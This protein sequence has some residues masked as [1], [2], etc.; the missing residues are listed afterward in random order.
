MIRALHQIGEEMKI[1]AKFGLDL[2]FGKAKVYV[3]GRGREERRSTSHPFMLS[4]LTSLSTF[5][6]GMIFK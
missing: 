3:L 1:S 5:D 6:G 4:P 2:I